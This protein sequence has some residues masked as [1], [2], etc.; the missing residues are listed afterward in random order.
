MEAAGILA[1]AER[2]SLVLPERGI[3]VALLDWGG[4]GPPA[5]LHHANGFCKGTWGLVAEGLWD[6]YRIIAV[7]ARGHG[8][9]SFLPGHEWDEQPFGWDCFAEDVVAVGEA[10]RRELAVPALALGIG[11]SFGGT[12]VLGAAARCPE[13]FERTVL[14]D[15]VTPPAPKLLDPERA[16][17]VSQR[18]ER[19]LKRRSDW[20]TLEEAREWWA[21]REFFGA[22]QPQAL[23][24]YV[25]DGLRRRDD[26][27]VELKCSPEVEAAVFAGSQ[28]D[29]G[30]LAERAAPPCLWVWAELGDF[31]L[32]FHRALVARMPA[33]HFEAIRAGHLI[34]MERPD[35]VVDAIRRFVV[36]GQGPEAQ[37]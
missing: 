25:Q 18:V 23:D 37:A 29:V 8:D 31:P 4:D 19:A 3:E 12:S 32:E 6:D 36:P 33:A 35:L 21:G 9:T 27:Q 15:P 17:Q 20:P 7:D 26:G 34:P 16:E 30:A 5:L 1:R 24:L 11:H 22:W 2:R 14:L 28:L 13:L 10:L